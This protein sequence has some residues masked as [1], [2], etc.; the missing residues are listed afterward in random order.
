MPLAPDDLF[1]LLERLGIEAA[2][3]SHPPVF[4]VEEARRLRGD[5]PGCHCKCLFVT[6]RRNGYWL[7]VA[8][9]EIRVDMKALAGLLGAKRLSFAGADD[10]RALLGVEP[11]SVTPFA[12][13]NDAAGRVRPVLDAAMMDNQIVNY[14]PLVNTMTTALA[15]ADVMRFL[16]ATGHEPL[17]TALPARGP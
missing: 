3:V 7:V 6:D 1:A 17:V 5:L 12:L 15:P 16:A 13:A 4:T 9:E 14:H 8:R 11:G 10:L 2:T